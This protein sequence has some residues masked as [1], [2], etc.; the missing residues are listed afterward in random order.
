MFRFLSSLCLLCLALTVLG[1]TAFAQVGR[2]SSTLLTNP[3]LASYARSGDTLTAPDGTR[4]VLSRRG[5]FVSGASVTLPAANAAQAGKL[6]GV[7]TGYGDDLAAAYTEYL[8]NPQV[9]LQ[10]AAPQ[11]TSVV[12]EQYRITTRQVGQRVSF[13]VQ[14]DEVP[15]SDFSSTRNALGAEQA[16]VVLRLFSDFQCPYCE[17]FETQTWPKLQAAL[18]TL[19]NQP[20]RF[21]FHQLPL[22]QLHPNARAAAEASECAAAQGQ[23]WAYKDALFDPKNWTIWTKA[24]NPNPNFIALAQILKLQGDKFQTCLANRDGKVLVDAGLQEATKVGVNGTPTL[25]V[26]GYRVPDAYDVDA[27]MQLIRYVQAK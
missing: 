23:F 21:E 13:D 9:K 24:A 27:I 2:L 18:K 8:G 12:A 5:D 15:Q 26:N 10:I 17:Q 4:I 3:L 6:L 14:L 19:P 25:Y 11:G 16:P 7:L 1:T 20:V 22:E